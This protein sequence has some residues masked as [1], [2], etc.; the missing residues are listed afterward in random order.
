[1][2]LARLVNDLRSV[3]FGKQAPRGF[4]TAG[5]LSDKLEDV[6]T[7]ADVVLLLPDLAR[8]LR[9]IDYSRIAQDIA[10]LAGVK[11]CVQGLELAVS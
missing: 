1:M 8:A 5:E 11:A 3:K 6:R 9:K 4:R 2:P 10:D 7:A